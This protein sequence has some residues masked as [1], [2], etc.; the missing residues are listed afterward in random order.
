MDG[1]GRY[2]GNLQNGWRVILEMWLVASFIIYA[3][4]LT[5]RD[6]LDRALD[7]SDLVM[8]LLTASVA[9]WGVQLTVVYSLRNH[10]RNTWTDRTRW[11]FEMITNPHAD[12]ANLETAVRSLIRQLNEGE[13]P[14]EE[15]TTVRDM[16]DNGIERRNRLTVETREG[17]YR[18]GRQR[19]S[20]P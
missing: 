3:A 16:I 20:R 17:W 15:I 6:G 2:A 13:V 4:A 5:L 14:D 19:R 1:S 11:A 8:P 10:D 7:L 9:L 12:V 18:E